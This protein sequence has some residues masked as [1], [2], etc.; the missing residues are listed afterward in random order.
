ME[1]NHAQIK[2]RLWSDSISSDHD[3][4]ARSH[5]DEICRPV[6]GLRLRCTARWRGRQ[7]PRWHMPLST[8]RV[9]HAGRRDDARD[10]AGFPHLHFL[11]GLCVTKV[12]LDRA[13]Q[14]FY[15]HLYS[16]KI[17]VIQKSRE[18]FKCI[19]PR[20]RA[21]RIAEACFVSTCDGASRAG[22]R[23]VGRCIENLEAIRLDACWIFARLFATEN[24]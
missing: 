23:M 18:Q 5:A 9:R 24:T 15:D 2:V 16:V 13:W 17:I 12:L 3:R 10:I 1:S 11:D 14:Y 7:M 20:H 6:A 4:A 8:I 19:S 21:S 22:Y